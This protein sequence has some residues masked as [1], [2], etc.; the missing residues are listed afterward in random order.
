MSD[1]NGATVVIVGTGASIGSGYKRCGHTLPGDRGFFGNPVVRELLGSGR[2]PALQLMLESFPKLHPMGLD[3][4]G[5]EEV[6]TFLE[7]AGKEFLRESV[8]FRLERDK[9]LEAIRRPE[10]QA[11]DEHCLCKRYREDQTIPPSDRID[12]LLLAGW[13]LRRL[14]SRVYD[15]LTPPHGTLPSY[16]HANRYRALLDKFQI[17][18]NDS[19][20]FISLN[21]DTVLEHALNEAQILWHYSHVHTRFSRDPHSIRILKPHGSLNWRFRG[22]EPPVE[23][24]TDYTLTPIACRSYEENRFEEAMIIPPTQ[25]KQAIMVAETQPPELVQLFRAIWREAVDVLATASRVF[26]IGYSFPPTDLH[27]HTLLHLVRYKRKFKEF[28]V[29]FFGHAHGQLDRSRGKT[30]ADTKVIAATSHIEVANP[31]VRTHQRLSDLSKFLGHTR[32]ARALRRCRADRRLDPGH[33]RARRDA[34]RD[35]F[36]PRGGG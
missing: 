34:S 35:R 24:E 4:V 26:V 21:Y 14:L 33:G 17:D 30:C 18:K 10:L 2:Y 29:R 19:R 31:H 5:L 28:D 12:L 32:A 15:D 16:D 1:S 6:W 3:S 13:D 8:D 27:L 22:N 11:D 9:W 25:I 36:D 7:F 20:I 23:I